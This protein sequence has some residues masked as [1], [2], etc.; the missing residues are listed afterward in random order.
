MG[1]KEK[2]SERMNGEVFMG[3]DVD[4]CVFEG[5]GEGRDIFGEGLVER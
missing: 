1:D 4:V 2:G 3:R 5:G